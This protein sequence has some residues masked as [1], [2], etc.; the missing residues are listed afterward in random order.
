[1]LLCNRMTRQVF[2]RRRTL[3]IRNDR[4]AAN[5]NAGIHSLAPSTNKGG[6]RGNACYSLCGGSSCSI[7]SWSSVGVKESI[8]FSSSPPLRQSH[9]PENTKGKPTEK[10][11]ARNEQTKKKKPVTKA[12]DP[13]CKRRRKKKLR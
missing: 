11:L 10:K 8:A 5:H 12:V 2:E 13:Y 6:F 4:G 9:Q 1:M 3:L 7:R